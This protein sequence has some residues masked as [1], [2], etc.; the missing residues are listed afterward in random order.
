MNK[1][2][3]IL[4]AVALVACG[5][6]HEKSETL[7]QAEKVHDNILKL[8]GEMANVMHSKVEMMESKLEAAVASGDSAMAMQLEQLNGKLDDLHNRFHELEENMAEI[9][10]HEHTHDHGD[11]DHHD[12]HDHVKQNVLEG[13]TDQEH[14]DIQTEQLNQLKALQEELNSIEL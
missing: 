12:D 5:G 14:L 10:G 3:L 11:H 13:L 4:F 6:G 8:S 9:P 2:I 1:L 7:K